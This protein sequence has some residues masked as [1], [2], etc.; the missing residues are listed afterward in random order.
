MKPTKTELKAAREGV[1]IYTTPEG[2]FA[3][4]WG[5]GIRVNQDGTTTDITRGEV[6][7]P[8][9]DDQ[10]ALNEMFAIREADLIVFDEVD[11]PSVLDRPL[12]RQ[13]I[14]DVEAITSKLRHKSPRNQR[15][16]IEKAFKKRRAQ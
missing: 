2:T 12:K 14:F 8:V 16:A 5:R 11:Q 15:R 6:F 1:L 4:Q 10:D 13:D 7:E 3:E 9:D